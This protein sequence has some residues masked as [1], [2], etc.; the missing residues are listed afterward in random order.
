MTRRL[1]FLLMAS[2]LFLPSLMATEKVMA[3]ELKI[4]I[5]SEGDG[6]VAAPGMGHR[7]L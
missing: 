7:A 2:F 4:E 6:D 5:L 1:F 3:E